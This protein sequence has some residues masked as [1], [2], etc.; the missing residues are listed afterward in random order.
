MDRVLLPKESNSQ[1]SNSDFSIKRE[2]YRQTGLAIT[3]E[4]AG[5]EIWGLDQIEARENE[6]IEWAAEYWADVE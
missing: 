2:T 1:A 6:L 5:Y 4:I 3:D